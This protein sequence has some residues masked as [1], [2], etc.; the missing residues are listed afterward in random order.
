MSAM[1]AASFQ[2]RMPETELDSPDAKRRRTEPLGSPHFGA[3]PTSTGTTTSAAS[4]A[5]RSK[6]G[7]LSGNQKPAHPSFFSPLRCPRAEATGT[8][9]QMRGKLEWSPTTNIVRTRTNSAESTVAKRGR[10]ASKND[11]GHVPKEPLLIGISLDVLVRQRTT[12]SGGGSKDPSPDSPRSF[13][14]RTSLGTSKAPIAE[15]AEKRHEFRKAFIEVLEHDRDYDL[16]KQEVNAIMAENAITDQSLRDLAKLPMSS[17]LLEDTKVGKFLKSSGLPKAMDLVE[18]WRQGVKTSIAAAYEIEKMIFDKY[19]TTLTSAGHLTNNGPGSPAT[20]PSGVSPSPLT[21]SV[22]PA[23][24]Q[25]PVRAVVSSSGRDA[26]F[27]YV[28]DL[29][30]LL[31]SLKRG[32]NSEHKRMLVKGEL[33]AEQFVRKFNEQPDVYNSPRV[34]RAKEEAKHHTENVLDSHA[35][36]PFWDKNLVCPKCGDTAHGSRYNISHLDVWDTWRGEDRT[37]TIAAQCCKC[38]YEWVRDE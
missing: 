9:P 23:W 18:Q 15:N 7:S 17:K 28:H 36:F 8:T 29:R 33:T 25:V 21:T 6:L 11:E 38:R 16:H 32:Y 1:S 13:S 24:E 3:V 10:T 27:Q 26:V 5:M 22:T 34:K 4:P 2:S 12:S 35:A 30:E 31:A 37:R 20:R 14:P 19:A